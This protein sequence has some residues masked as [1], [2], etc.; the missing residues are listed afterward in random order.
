M[1]RSHRWAPQ[2][3]VGCTEEG[4]A[5][6]EP[7]CPHEG[8]FLSSCPFPEAWDYIVITVF[9]PLSWPLRLHV[10]LFIFHLTCFGK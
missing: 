4:P 8:H 9:D 10:G 3:A 7:G 6:R 5:T 1:P 2:V